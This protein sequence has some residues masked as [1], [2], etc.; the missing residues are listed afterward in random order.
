MNLSISLLQHYNSSATLWYDW[1]NR[2]FSQD[3]TWQK[4]IAELT[5][6]KNI[7]HMHLC[8][9][10]NLLS[11]DKNG[12]LSTTHR[13]CRDSSVLAKHAGRESEMCLVQVRFLA[14]HRVYLRTKGQNKLSDCFIGDLFLTAQVDTFQWS[15]FPLQNI[16]QRSRFII[17]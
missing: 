17:A 5:L 9:Y 4:E 13:Y 8:V 15:D 14:T 11:L 6:L 3:L 1:S 7:G 12:V 2:N 16:F 10:L